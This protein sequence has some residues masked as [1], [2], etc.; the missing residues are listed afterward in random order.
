MAEPRDTACR[1]AL[2]CVR[3]QC[4]RVAEMA[5]HVRIHHDRVPAYAKRLLGLMPPTPMLDRDTHF[6]G[7]T[8][9]TAAFFV[10]LDAINFGSGYFPYLRKRNG[11]SGYFT[12][13]SAL[14]DQFRS[15]GAL[16]AMQL[17]SAT[18]EFCA[19]VFGQSLENT[20]IAKLMTAFAQ[21]WRDLGDDL[22]RRFAGSFNA[23]IESAGH[24]A[25]ALVALLNEQ[26]MFRDIADYKDLEVPF[27]KRSQLLASDLALAFQNSGLGRFDDLDQLTIFSDNLVPHVLRLDGILEYEHA[28]QQCIDH[29]ELIPAGSAQE[30]EI[31]ACSV[32]AVE[33]ICEAASDNGMHFTSRDLDQILWHRG[34]DP[35]YKRTAKRH[36]TR[37]IFY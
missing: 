19:E 12:I 3:S 15:Q 33:E 8:E 24:S 4:A 28:L 22:I 29:E 16:T 26:P 23:L 13:A 14:T 7:N 32:T 1:D 37:S 20:V 5:D 30:I 25:A 9:E 31:R 10:C 11:M 6:A 34:Q 17:A 2:H 27:Y 35:T 18:P 21:S 36:R